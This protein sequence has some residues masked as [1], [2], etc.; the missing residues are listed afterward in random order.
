MNKMILRI[1]SILI[2][3]ISTSIFPVPVTI[4]LFIVTVSFFKKFYE[5]ILAG[6]FLDS[7]YFSPLLFSKFNLGFFTISFLI[8]IPLIEKVKQ[9]TQEENYASK[10]MLA[11][12]SAIPLYIFILFFSHI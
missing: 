2:L 6:I 8:T 1:T 3:L 9:L 5:G 11:L 10:I 7:L 12:A 4:A